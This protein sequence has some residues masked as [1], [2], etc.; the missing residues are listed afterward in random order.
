MTGVVVGVSAPLLYV[1]RLNRDG[2]GEVCRVE[3]RL[4]DCTQQWSPWPWLVVG[5]ALATVGV[6][7]FRALGHKAEPA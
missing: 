2:L 6:T 7:A 3:E 4:I 1:A 5:L